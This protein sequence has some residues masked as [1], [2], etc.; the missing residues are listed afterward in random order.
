MADVRGL[1]TALGEEPGAAR[2]QHWFLQLAA[3]VTPYRGLRYETLGDGGAMI[4]SADTPG[5]SPA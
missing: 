1:L 4:E 5:V 2:A 3:A